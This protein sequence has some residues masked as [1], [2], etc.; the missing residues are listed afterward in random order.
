MECFLAYLLRYSFLHT[1]GLY[2][3]NGFIL[4]TIFFG[5]HAQPFPKSADLYLEDSQFKFQ[6]GHQ[7]SPLRAS[8]VSIRPSRQMLV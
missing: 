4:A 5:H 2:A 8:M 6:P 3:Y 7:L 1:A